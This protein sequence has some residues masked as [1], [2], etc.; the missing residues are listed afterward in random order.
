M[1]G[2]V[3]GRS[4][5]IVTGASGKVGSVLVQ[6]LLEQFDDSFLLHYYRHADPLEALKEKWARSDRLHLLQADLTEKKGIQKLIK[7]IDK[8]NEKISVFIHLASIF[9]ESPLENLNMR[10]MERLFNI[11][12]LAPLEVIRHL[13][14]RFRPGGRIILFSDAGTWVG[15]ERYLGYTMS[16]AMMESALPVLARKLAPEVTIHGIAPY[17]VE[18]TGDSGIGEKVLTE[19]V[20]MDALVAIVLWLIKHGDS[21]TGRIF[22]LDSGRFVGM[23]GTEPL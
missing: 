22:R 10:Q 21:C 8:I 6:T 5:F 17:L 2:E 1:A 4:W 19:P 18:S 23:W 13:K 11:H 12:V 16:R 14:G 9:P 3:E 15:Y 20:K 7:E